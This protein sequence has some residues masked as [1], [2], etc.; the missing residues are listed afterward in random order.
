M[1]L[2]KRRLA[3]WVREA[4]PLAVT[5]GLVL[6]VQTMA[7]QPFTV[8]T[9]SMIPT[10]QIGDEVVA[11]KFAYGWS[12]YS[13]PIGL[14]P[15]FSGR[16][17]DRAPQRGDV[18]VFRLPRDTSETYVKRVIGLPG[19]RIRMSGGQLYINGTMVSRRA[20]GTAD[21][22]WHGSSR[23][24]TRYI[25][26]LPDGREHVIQKLPGRNPLDD[27]PE[28]TVPPG[29]YF[30]MGD[31]RDDSLDSRVP[32]ERGGV[33]FVPEENLLGRADVVLFSRNP[34]V[35]WWDVAHWGDA[36]RGKRTLSWIE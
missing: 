19:D 13:S 4:A 9:G 33:G 7:A 16:I 11:S 8:P 23:T 17:L 22:D 10:I 24:Y 3:G 18:I 28:V 12:K 31:N 32:A 15:D 25:E 34:Q 1:T 20:D 35:A 26:S 27:T 2:W 5:L 6:T 30:M 29:H 14:M 21:A 36:F